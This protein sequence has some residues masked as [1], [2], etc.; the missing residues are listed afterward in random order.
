MKNLAPNTLTK[1]S[2]IAWLFFLQA[3][4]NIIAPSGGPIDEAPPQKIDSLSYPN[5][6]NNTNRNG[7]NIV[8]IFDET[9][10]VQSLKSQ[11]TST[12]HIDNKAITYSTKKVK[13]KNTQGKTYK[14]TQVNISLNQELD[15]NTTYVLNFGNA[16][17][18]INEG[19]IAS[20]IS[21]AFSTGPVIDSLSIS[22]K[23]IDNFS[24][25][26]VEEVFVGLYL[27]DSSDAQ[28]H[29]PK[30]FTSTNKEGAFTL[31]YLKYGKY[32]LVAFKD[33]NRNK[34]LD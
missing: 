15:T 14:G 21:I 6:N 12:P 2:L 28:K 32:R 26:P 3:C 34:K 11:L 29:L 25:K 22:G 18:D 7:K 9:T 13:L 31:N 27:K 10:E 33:L 19:K 4:A 23:V 1:L 20:N 24:N 17:K 16:F 30:Y 5:P 8:M